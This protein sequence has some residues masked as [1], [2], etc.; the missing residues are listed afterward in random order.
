MSSPGASP[1]ADDDSFSSQP[2]EA[3]RKQP[4]SIL[5]YLTTLP[6]SELSALYQDPFSVMTVFRSLPAV[7]RQLIMRLLLLTAPSGVPHSLALSFLGTGATRA[8]G[9]EALV[10]RLRNLHII[11]QVKPPVQQQTGGDQQ[12]Q[13]KQRHYQLNPAF[14]RCLINAL[15]AVP[16]SASASASSN[17]NKRASLPATA[18]S[19]APKL[20]LSF[21]N[22]TSTD[23]TK[24]KTDAASPAA[25]AAAD[26]ASAAAAAAA[27]KPTAAVAAPVTVTLAL[28]DTTV[29]VPK[30]RR[31]SRQTVSSLDMHAR[32]LWARFLLWLIGIGQVHQQPPSRV[33][34]LAQG[35]GLVAPLPRGRAGQEELAFRLGGLAA[36]LGSRDIA[37]TPTGVAFLFKPQPAQVWQVVLYYMDTL[38]QQHTSGGS[39]SSSNGASSL[40][41]DPHGNNNTA[42]S[43][44]EMLR[45]VFRLCFLTLGQEYS[46]HELSDGQRR[47]LQDFRGLGTFTSILLHLLFVLLYFLRV[48]CF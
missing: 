31:R 12:Q 15:C 27:T 2:G 30:R 4:D 20:S 43:R 25:D 23:D 9:S 17:G 19:A 41:S 33:R 40:S 26:A 39:G 38:Q 14:Q 48:C 34:A 16:P 22:S 6:K 45:L 42:V 1:G 35:M 10:D 46:T 18:G 37:I 24:N 13:Q 5:T 44:D 28:N 36:H 3:V 32:A 21:A 7:S 11:S 8:L 47:I 29:P